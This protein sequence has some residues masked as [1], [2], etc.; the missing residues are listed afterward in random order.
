MVENINKRYENM[1]SV[2]KTTA[3]KPSAKTTKTI[4]SN[5]DLTKPSTI[6]YLKSQI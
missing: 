4:V 6:D 1:I 2:I 3:S 5:G